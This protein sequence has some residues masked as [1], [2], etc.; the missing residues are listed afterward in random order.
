M[1][2]P[3]FADVPYFDKK[4]GGLTDSALLYQSEL[5][6]ALQNGLSDNGWTVPQ[7]T[8]ANLVAIAPSMGDG[9][10]WYETDNNL[11]VVK[12]NG[13]LEKVTTTPYP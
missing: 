5:N 2:I 3:V 8:A 11:L 13:S 10:I 4:D 6:Q 7:I 9:T 12:I 1:Q